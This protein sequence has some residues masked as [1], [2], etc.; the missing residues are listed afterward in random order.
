MTPRQSPTGLKKFDQ[1]FQP[2]RAN[3]CIHEEVEEAVG[4]RQIIAC[5]LLAERVVAGS[6]RAPNNEQY[7]D[8]FPYGLSHDGMLNCDSG[9]KIS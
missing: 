3:V 6:V 1:V 8:V 9:L 2:Y 7:N 4:V 5:C